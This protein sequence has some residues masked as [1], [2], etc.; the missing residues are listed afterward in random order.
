MNPN[1]SD[2]VT[3]GA[4][5]M[6][7]TRGQIAELSSLAEAGGRYVDRWGALERRGLIERLPGASDW[8]SHFEAPTEWRLTAAGVLVVNLLFEAGLSNRGGAGLARECDAL[9][10]QLAAANLALN[11]T[12]Q[13]LRSIYARHEKLR[14]SIQQA[15]DSAA[16]DRITIRITPRDPLPDA[17]LAELA[18]GI[19]L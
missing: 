9:R 12:R 7:L 14:L 16:G 17:T 1:F 3:S 11:E 13:K 6:S 2:Y 5:N 10:A 8:V 4:F 19:D 15:E 18:E